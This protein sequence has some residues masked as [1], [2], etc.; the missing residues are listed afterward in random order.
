VHRHVGPAVEQGV[1]DLLGEQ[2]VAADLR[3]GPVAHAVALGLDQ[4][5]LHGARR[6]QRPQ[7]RGHVIR[8]PQR[9]RTASGAQS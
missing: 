5:Q 2:A 9:Q 6:G 1:L 3:Q 7:Q 8:L 4:H